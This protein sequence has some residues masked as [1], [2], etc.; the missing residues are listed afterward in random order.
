MRDYMHNLR[1]FGGSRYGFA[2]GKFKDGKR[3]NLFFFIFEFF[4]NILY[5]QFD[6][7]FFSVSL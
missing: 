5:N 3:N 2:F 1:K 6:I 7:S 4:N